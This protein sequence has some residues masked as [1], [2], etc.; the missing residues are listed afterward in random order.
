MVQAA[1]LNEFV[2]APRTNGAIESCEKL[3]SAAKADIHLWGFCGTTE[4]V[5]FHK[6]RC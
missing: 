5:P 2:A 1:F 4:V 6:L 3:P